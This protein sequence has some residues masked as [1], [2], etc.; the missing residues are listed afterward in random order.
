[1]NQFYERLGQWTEQYIEAVLRHRV[2]VV[3]GALLFVLLCGAGG[4]RLAFYW[5]YGVFCKY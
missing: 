4:A 1:M 2:A 3:V 5:Y